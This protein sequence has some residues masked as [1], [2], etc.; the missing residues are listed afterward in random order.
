[1]MVGGDNES[2]TQLVD[3]GVED[4]MKLSISVPTAS[5]PHNGRS[6]SGSSVLVC[7]CGIVVE[8]WELSGSR[9]M[10]VEVIQPHLPVRLPCYDFTPVTSPAFDIP[11]FA[12]KV[13]TSGMASS[14][15]VTGS[16]YKA[17]E[18]IHRRLADR[19][20]LAIPTSW[21]RVV[22]YNPN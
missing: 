11:F 5:H 8:I 12:V 1:M 10:I 7:C 15:S 13:T 6:R 4:A 19:Q 2:G 21:R 9:W 16:V 22:T 3:C 20:L 14:H 17:R 18:R